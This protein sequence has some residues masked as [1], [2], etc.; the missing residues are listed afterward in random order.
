[1][2][3]KQTLLNEEEVKKI[4]SLRQA[5]NRSFSNMIRFILQKALREGNFD[6]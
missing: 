3:R 6:G 1:M 2:I 5:E 4:D